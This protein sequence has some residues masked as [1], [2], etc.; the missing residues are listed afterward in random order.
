M[1]AVA[2]GIVGAPP[3]AE[4]L[5]VGHIKLRCLTAEFP[6]FWLKF[7]D[8][9]VPTQHCAKC[10]MGRWSR[11]VPF[12][13][14][15]QGMTVNAPTNES[16]APFLY[17]CG[18]ST[19]G[20]SHN[21]HVAMRRKAGAS[22]EVH[23]HQIDLEMTGWERLEIPPLPAEEVARME[24]RGLGKAF[25]TCRNYQFGWHYARKLPLAQ[26]SLL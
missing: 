5:E 19:K 13:K 16:D 20:Y 7:V 26:R 2:D 3:R 8:G 24:A 17:L 1:A 14:Q 12:I 15:K 9:F 11:L 10:L 25:H 18:V 22:F 6:Y 23:S 4:R 21:L